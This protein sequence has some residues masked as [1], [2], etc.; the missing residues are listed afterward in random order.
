[1]ELTAMSNQV[2]KLKEQLAAKDEDHAARMAALIE[3]FRNLSGVMEFIGMHC[4][5]AWEELKATH[6][7]GEEG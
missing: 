4:E 6:C 3:G 1:M 2:S 7:K 5:E